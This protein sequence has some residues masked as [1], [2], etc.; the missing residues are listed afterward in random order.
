MVDRNLSVR[1]GVTR[2]LPFPDIHPCQ[3]W[4]GTHVRARHAKSGFE[5]VELAWDDVE[6]PSIPL[7]A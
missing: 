5:D 3:V 6:T 2:R 4:A 7:I 1:C